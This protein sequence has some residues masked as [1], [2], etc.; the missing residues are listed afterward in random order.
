MHEKLISVYMI[1]NS[2]GSDKLII[3]VKNKGPK[4]KDVAY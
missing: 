1:T 3:S 4:I 2:F